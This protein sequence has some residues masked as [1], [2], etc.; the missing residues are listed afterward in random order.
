MR[1][2]T[3]IL[4]PGLLFAGF[5]LAADPPDPLPRRGDPGLSVREPS[6][7]NRW[8]EV[9]RVRPGGAGA[10]AGL[11]PKDHILEIDGKPLADI[12]A[13]SRIYDRIRGAD[14]IRFT[15]ERAGNRF[16]RTV[17]VPPMPREQI[18]GIDVVY[19]SVTSDRGHRLRTILT[20]PRGKSGRLPGLFLVGWLSCDSV[21]SP[22]GNPDGFARF[23]REVITGSGF[24]LMRVD[25]PGVGDSEGP[26][27]AET[28][29]AT[30][31]AGY[32]AAF[33]AFA[34]SPGVDPKRIV[35]MGM[36]NGGGFA[37]L[38]VG[39]VPV[40]GFIVS[41]GWGKTWL[42]HMLEIERRRLTL[43]GLEPGEVSRRMVGYAELYDRYLNGKKTPAGVIRER[44][45]LAPLWED[46]PAHQY[47]RPAA[48]YQQLQATNLAAAWQKVRVPVLAVHGEYDWIMSREDHELIAAW[49]NRNRPGAGKF[50]QIPKMDH[51]YRR[52]ASA[53]AAFRNENGVYTPEASAAVLSWLR[54]L[55]PVEVSGGARS[56]E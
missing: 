16:E 20:R 54:E 44:P 42:E 30:E 35:V 32:R 34:G 41:G 1:K 38:V 7:E 6:G 43:S 53:P 24:V 18:D 29:F 46:D 2:V 25:K 36:S 4:A 9:V 27:C 33:L 37:P 12:V 28:D 48:F 55:G 14:R 3:K 45:S 40:S 21:E 11:Q 39:D 19:G 26:A 23:L 17:V 31:L 49:V 50:V 56:D 8:A 51:G 13:F 47:G 5:A 15:V 52:Y 22:T 10:T